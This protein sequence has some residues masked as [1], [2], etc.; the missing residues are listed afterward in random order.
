[1]T[2]GLNIMRNFNDT[3][4]KKKKDRIKLSENP[5]GL[6]PEELSKLENTVKSSLK[7]GYLPCPVA[8]SI[9]KNA[10]VPRIAVGEIADRFGIRVTDCQLGCFKV[11]KTPYDNTTQQA[12][13][14]V[15]TARLDSL[16]VNSEL[17][18]A[19]VFELA[20]QLKSTP[21]KIA[22]VINARNMKIRNCQ[23][24]CF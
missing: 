18:C 7:D 5:V 12:V 13:D 23:L 17:T 19:G 20:R 22:D 24:G 9:A 10:G 6:S 16:V 8:W 21:M 3:D 2:I 15:I 4:R 1:M 14:D 11:G